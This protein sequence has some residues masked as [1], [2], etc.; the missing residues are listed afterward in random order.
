VKAVLTRFN[1]KSRAQSTAEYAILIGL[2]IAAAV[3]MQVYVKRTLQGRMRG[4]VHY[5][6]NYTAACAEGRG[7]TMGNSTQYEPYYLS[8][9]FEVTR[10][11][12]AQQGLTAGGAYSAN[13]VSITNRASGTQGYSAPEQQ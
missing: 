12:N 2:V 11:Q 1:R 10:G 4:A 7:I 6:A 8:S 3:A 13:E 9:D 5:L